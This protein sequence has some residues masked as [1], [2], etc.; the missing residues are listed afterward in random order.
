ME[1]KEVFE[2]LNEIFSKNDIAVC[3]GGTGLYIKALC[4]GID[5]M[6]E[7]DK[8]IEAE[9]HALYKE[10]GITYLQNEIKLHD[11]FFF[12]NG[13]IQNPHRLIRALV[14]KK[15]IG[16]SILEYKKRLCTIEILI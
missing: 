3:V 12:Q 11:A 16:I 8:Q 6:P 14:F 9:V 4:E 10:K 2:K 5:E 15:S 7:V 1:R 13:E